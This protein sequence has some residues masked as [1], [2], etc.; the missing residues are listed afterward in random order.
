MVD[1]MTCLGG[2]AF[3]PARKHIEVTPNHRKSDEHLPQ[4]KLM[5]RGKAEK[6]R[7]VHGWMSFVIGPSC[8]DV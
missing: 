7:G 3:N 8:P 4:T 5:S 2:E 1:I 6:D